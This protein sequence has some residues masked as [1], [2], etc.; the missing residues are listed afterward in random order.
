MENK[1]ILDMYTPTGG[2]LVDF[3]PPYIGSRYSGRFLNL[4]RAEKVKV[5]IPPEP[6]NY[7]KKWSR[8][9]RS[10]L[11]SLIRCTSELMVDFGY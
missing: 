2:D 5:R 4:N 9:S 7:P 1:D 6:P 10:P 8:P 3:I 11:Q